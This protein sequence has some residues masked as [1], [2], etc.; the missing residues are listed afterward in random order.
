MDHRRL[1]TAGAALVLL[2][3]GSVANAKSADVVNAAP[4]QSFSKLTG[5]K[6]I[7]DSA[8]RLAC[9]DKAVTELEQA[10]ASKQV[11]VADK[12]EIKKTRKGLFGFNLPKLGLFGGDDNSDESDHIEA[13]IAKATQLGRNGPWT[14]TLED[15]AKWVQTQGDIFPPPAPGQPIK[16]RKGTMGSYIANVNGQRGVQV[17]RKN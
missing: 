9:Y 11:Y 15:G 4:P 16:I 17:E 14:I 6:A 3:A 5:C 1:K 10:V 7:V 12:E 13:I 8:A 2:S